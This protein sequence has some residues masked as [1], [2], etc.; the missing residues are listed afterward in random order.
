[1]DQLQQPLGMSPH[2]HR[3]PSNLTNDKQINKINEVEALLAMSHDD[4]RQLGWTESKIRI[5]ESNRHRAVEK[6]GQMKKNL[7]A[8]Q[9]QQLPMPMQ[10][11]DN[12]M[13][14]Q[15]QALQN[16]EL[17][18][19]S[20]SRSSTTQEL[21]ATTSS[22]GNIG[23]DE[24]KAHVSE[25][26]RPLAS[27][28]AL[29]Q[30]LFDSQQESQLKQEQEG[31]EQPQLQGTQEQLH[32]E[33]AEKMETLDITDTVHPSQAGSQATSPTPKNVLNQSGDLVLDGK[34]DLQEQSSILDY[35]TVGDWIPQMMHTLFSPEQLENAKSHTTNILN[36]FRERGPPET[37]NL[38]LSDHGVTELQMTRMHGLVMEAAKNL[39]SFYLLL[40]QDDQELKQAAFIVSRWMQQRTILAKPIE[41]KRFIV[42][43]NHLTVWQGHLTRF[44]EHVTA[45]ARPGSQATDRATSPLREDRMDRAHRMPVV[46]WGMQRLV[47][48]G[49]PNGFN[50]LSNTQQHH[51]SDQHLSAGLPSQQDGAL[52]NE[53]QRQYA[54]HTTQLNS[55]NNE[56]S[57]QQPPEATQQQP[58]HATQYQQQPSMLS[59]NVDYLQHGL[60]QVMEAVDAQHR[61]RDQ[62]APT[63]L[64]G[65]SQIPGSDMPK[66]LHNLLPQGVPPSA[67]LR[68]HRLRHQ[69]AAMIRAQ[70]QRTSMFKMQD[71]MNPD[72]SGDIGHDGTA[73]WQA[74]MQ[75]Q[76]QQINAAAEGSSIL[77]EAIQSH[78]QNNILAPANARL[79]SDGAGGATVGHS[80]TNL[81][82]FEAML[83]RQQR[84]QQQQAQQQAAQ[85]SKLLQQQQHH[86]KIQA[87]VQAQRKQQQEQSIGEMPFL[88]QQQQGQPGPSQSSQQGQGQPGPN[89]RSDHIERLNNLPVE[90]L[91][92]EMQAVRKK[93][94]DVKQ[95]QAIVATAL[96]TRPDAARLHPMVAQKLQILDHTSQ[97]LTAL[98]GEMGKLLQA[99]KH[100]MTIPP[101]MGGADGKNGGAGSSGQQQQVG[102]ATSAG[103]VIGQG[104]LPTGLGGGMG[105]VQGMKNSLRGMGQ[106]QDMAIENTP[107]PHHPGWPMHMTPQQAQQLQQQ[108]LMQQQQQQ[109]KGQVQ[110]WDN[111]F[112][113]AFQQWLQVVK[114]SLDKPMIEGK[115]VDLGKLFLLVGGAGGYDQAIATGK[116][117]LIGANIG[118]PHYGGQ[119]GEPMQAAPNV[120]EQLAKIYER[121]LLRFE[122]HWYHSLRQ[123]DPMAP[124]PLPKHLQHL[125]PRLQNILN[126]K[127]SAAGASHQHQQ[128]T[129]PQP[130]QATTQMPQQ[131]TAAQQQT[132]LQRMAQ[133][134]QH[135]QQV[136]QQQ[137]QQLPEAPVVKREA[138]QEDD[139]L[140]LSWMIND[141]YRRDGD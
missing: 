124:I 68:D 92:V 71:A 65:L 70:K 31:L 93:M 141:S 58:L 135:Q 137:Q 91:Y 10:P 103:S 83:A 7:D 118:F 40:P 120:T 99:K 61:L 6:V 3:S 117:G 41:Q 24:T 19:Q 127:G 136:A 138:K 125:H 104:S 36:S 52:W 57:R 119:N 72:D 81:P 64:L 25:E 8:Q 15:L 22:L 45:A 59:P 134:Q 79:R 32:Q 23:Q 26:R 109:Q 69:Y 105:N 27:G 5:F 77:S 86:Q 73:N 12:L 46:S 114:L 129:Q 18:A 98:W 28:V 34:P 38:P 50:N 74:V 2:N 82:Q 43:V 55:A 76:Q 112:W 85:A 9:G 4:L 96:Q 11:Q 60:S 130:Q 90:Q 37:L 123:Q 133:A 115:D 51:L 75:Q 107:A 94:E 128:Q 33:V 95:Q 48:V 39:P 100:L 42:G 30:K 80:G 54:Q 67:Q 122:Q 20:D 56:N 101:G 121:L 87:V 140:D 62:V 110:G 17:L 139:N 29:K 89:S 84:A 132:L 14:Q 49:A 102:A 47:S 63:G 13:T 16:Q 78:N 113:T 111:F 21:D 35:D 1:M 126:P 53:L 108:H 97:S 88:G 66:D 131:I 44:L 106:A 116:W